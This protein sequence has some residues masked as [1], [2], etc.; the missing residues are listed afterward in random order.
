MER[1]RQSPEPPESGLQHRLAL[2]DTARIARQHWGPARLT[3]RLERR[4]FMRGV[5]PHGLDEVW[6]EI[7]PLLQLRVDI[8]QGRGDALAKT[9]EA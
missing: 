6:N 8:A 5:A 3:D 1:A 9:D 7:V 4:P 2:H